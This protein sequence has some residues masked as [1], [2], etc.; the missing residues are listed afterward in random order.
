[1]K[2][3]K[4]AKIA[5]YCLIIGWF[6]FMFLCGAGLW[7]DVVYRVPIVMIGLGLCWFGSMTLTTLFRNNELFQS[8]DELDE[9]RWKYIEATKRLEQK[10]KQL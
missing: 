1:M 7:L 10:I 4:F 3:Q 2:T 9:A 6:P 8:I 5:S